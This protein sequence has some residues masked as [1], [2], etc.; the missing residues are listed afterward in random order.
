[1]RCDSDGGC[2]LL[3]GKYEPNPKVGSITSVVSG[4]PV[5]CAACVAIGRPRIRATEHPATRSCT[6]VGSLYAQDIASYRTRHI[7]AE[8]RQGELRPANEESL[9]FGR[10]RCDQR[11]KRK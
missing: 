4:K 1:M 5:R 7:P 2:S 6:N 8:K 9:G 10:G 3:V 11:R